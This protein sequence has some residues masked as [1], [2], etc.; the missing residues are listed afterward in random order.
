MITC[1]SLLPQK[2]DNFLFVGEDLKLGASNQKQEMATQHQLRDSEWDV[3]NLH[4]PHAPSRAERTVQCVFRRDTNGGEWEA[5]CIVAP[6][7]IL[8][9]VGKR[10][11]GLYA[12]AGFQKN[13]FVGLYD[14]RVVGTFPSRRAA[15]DSNRCARLVRAEYDKLITR[16]PIG[17]GRGVELVDGSAGGPPFLHYINDP[18][19]SGLRPNTTL[20]PA[21]TSRLYRA[22]LLRSTSPAAARR[23][24]RWR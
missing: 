24:C 23:P 16:R 1:L 9:R 3:A 21:D 14:G 7:A 17:G 15:L 5:W 12:A 13:D 6:S 20:I 8:Q 11:L 19:G 18:R 22:A 10:G 4:W 2:L